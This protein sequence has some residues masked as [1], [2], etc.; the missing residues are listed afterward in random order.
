MFVGTAGVEREL[1]IENLL[2][3]TD[4]FLERGRT[5]CDVSIPGLSISW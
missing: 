4:Q 5:F 3:G 2:C 1:F